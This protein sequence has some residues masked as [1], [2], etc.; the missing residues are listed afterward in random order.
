MSQLYKRVFLVCPSVSLAWLKDLVSSVCKRVSAAYRISSSSSS[1]SPS[2]FSLTASC[3]SSSP[4]A[5]LPAEAA[6][7]FPLWKEVAAML[8]LLLLSSEHFRD[9]SRDLKDQNHVMS[10][11]L[12]S[13]LHSD[14]LFQTCAPPQV[15]LLLL[16]AAVR[17]SPFFTQHPT[18]L[19][20]VLQFMLGP[21]GINASLSDDASNTPAPSLRSTTGRL[22]SARQRRKM[23]LS[24]VAGR[25]C[26]SLLRFLKHTQPQVSGF[27]AQILQFLQS[28]S[29][30]VIVAPSLPEADPAAVNARGACFGEGLAQTGAALVANKLFSV[31]DQQMLFEAAG[32]LLGARSSSSN[33]KQQARPESLA[34]EARLLN[35]TA[36]PDASQGQTNEGFSVE[37][38]RRMLRDLLQQLM[39]AFNLT[40]VR[41]LRRRKLR[42]PR[43]CPE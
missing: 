35:G 17:F 14:A 2:S 20:G 37:E 7:S 24:R 19:P 16:S 22:R 36:Q 10:S 31:A 42:V 8:Q 26:V 12:I 9:L 23:L 43:V 28:Q 3:P 25:S 39:G 11:C 1:S 34:G 21:A 13:V 6:P 27:G 40:K 41:R 38:K 15:R 4:S 29:C 33:S 32:V 18:F 30:L 5:S